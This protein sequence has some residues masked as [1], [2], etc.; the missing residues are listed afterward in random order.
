[1]LVGSFS[2]MNI[3]AW[4]ICYF[5]MGEYQGDYTDMTYAEVSRTQYSLYG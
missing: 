3:L 2:D 5:I 4:P 1:M